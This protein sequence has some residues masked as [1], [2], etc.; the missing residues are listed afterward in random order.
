MLDKNALYISII[1]YLIISFIILYYKPS[2][3]F[4]DKNKKKLKVFGTGKNKNKSIF[5][6]WFILFIIGIVIYFTVCCILTKIQNVNI[7]FH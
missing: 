7:D 3:L 1:I 4:V 6:F 2:F 5:P